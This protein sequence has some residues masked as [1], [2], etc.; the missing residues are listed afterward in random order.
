MSFVLPGNLVTPVATLPMTLDSATLS[1]AFVLLA[2]V[3]GGLLVFAWALNQKVRALAWWGA[4]FCLIASGIA[5]VNLGKASVSY[6]ALLA[7]NSLALLSYAALF[8]GC[9]LFNGRATPI[10][11]V[12]AGVA[13]WCV[14]F[15]FIYDKPGYRLVLIALAAGAYALLSAWELWRHARQ[16]LASQ[17]VAIVLL[18]LLAVLNIARAGLGVTLTSIAWIDALA[19]RWS[20]EM[21]LFLVVFTPTLAFIFLSMAK[22]SVEFGYKQAAFIDPLTGIPNRRAF[23]QHATRLIRSTKGKTV[24]CLV[25]DLDNFKRIN[26]GY[27]HDVGDNVLIL[28]G[29]IL[30]RHLP[31]QSFGRLGGEE[32]AAILPVSMQE[33]TGKAEAVRRAFSKASKDMIGAEVTVSVGCSASKSAA[34]ETLLQEADLALYRAKDHGRN[35]VVSA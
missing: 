11:L 28:F 34:V 16:P 9:R 23:M 19:S 26:D 33:A 14:A 18:V 17:R 4:A 22:E 30:E 13:I 3:L 2:M 25:F 10:A 35:V 27:G 20:T 15:P 32:F 5:V 6:T 8:A 29:D 12:G 7:G 24:S 21:A 31:K 1:V